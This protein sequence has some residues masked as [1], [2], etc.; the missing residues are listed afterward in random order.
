MK[1]TNS[2]GNDV[3]IYAE[4]CEYD[5]IEQ[6]K[7]VSNFEA[8]LESKIRIM[9]D[10]HYGKGCTVGTTMTISDKITPN[11]VGVD[12]SCGMLC[13]KL[14]TKEIDLAKLDAVV[15]KFVPSGFDV[16]DRP[17]AKYD[18][19]GLAC[20]KHVDHA[21][22]SHSIGS[23]GG[24]N[25][26]I[27]LNKSELDGTLYL[28]IH[29]GSRKLG[30]DV[31]KYYQD[32]AFF[33][34]N[35]MTKVKAN[36]IKKL[37]AEGRKKDID[38]ELK[39]LQKPSADKDLAFLTGQDFKDYMNDMM[40]L[41]GYASINRNTIADIILNKMG[42]SSVERFE[43]LHNYIDQK[44]MILRKGAISAE[45][46]EVVLIPMNMRD[47]SLLCVGKGNPDWNYSA[48]HGAGR[49]YSRNK[50][51]EKI[52]L[53][54]FSDTMSGVYTTSVCNSTIDE[55]PQAYKPMEEIAR[56]ITDTV[57]VIDRLIPVYNFKAH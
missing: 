53:D 9:P 2:I 37:K 45:A 51:K 25:H 28:V 56:L 29:T 49:L 26:F 1:I 15:N 55:A 40:I 52:T 4:T 47:G 57:D 10:F 7:K 36:L 14:N 42:L 11:L 27:E 5:A 38:S 8:Y 48:P 43:T 41:Q 13:C 44:R 21:R 33:D 35:D 46:G 39:K 20:F 31:C 32:K 19:T 12:I 18:L 34:V 16:H 3:I 17:V 6:I 22:A 30:S 54:E 24:G 50:A 23:L